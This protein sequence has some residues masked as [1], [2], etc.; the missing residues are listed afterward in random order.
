M[1]T[2]LGDHALVCIDSIATNDMKKLLIESLRTG[3]HKYDIIKLSY[4]Q[5]EQMC[6]NMQ[7]IIN[8]D[9]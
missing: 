4:D 7:C 9:G 8:S 2:I 6:A 3:V 1:I 5:I